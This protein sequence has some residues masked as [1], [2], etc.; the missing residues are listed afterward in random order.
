MALLN[1]DKREKGTKPDSFNVSLLPSSRPADQPRI[2]AMPHPPSRLHVLQT[3]PGSLHILVVNRPCTLLNSLHNCDD[4]GRHRQGNSSQRKACVITVP[5]PTSIS[6]T[7]FT[8]TAGG[9]REPT[10]IFK[11]ALSTGGSKRKYPLRAFSHTHQR[12]QQFQSSFASCG[13]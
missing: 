13:H 9:K 10:G 1:A 6:R 5:K 7:G 4:H 8:S 2:P 3:L 12:K 11:E